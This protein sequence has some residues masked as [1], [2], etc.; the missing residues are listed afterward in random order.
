MI[1][2]QNF[3]DLPFFWAFIPLFLLLPFFLFYSKSVVSMVSSY[4]EPDERILSMAGTITKVNRIVYGHTHKSRHEMIGAIE[5]LNSGT[6]SPAFTD[7][8]CTKMIDSKTFV[9]LEPG[10]NN[11]RRAS[12]LIFDGEKSFGSLGKPRKKSSSER[13]AR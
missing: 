2:A 1:L 10:D 12:L 4:K 11:Q 9:W 13:K 3:F 6:W 5:H 7:V 8:E